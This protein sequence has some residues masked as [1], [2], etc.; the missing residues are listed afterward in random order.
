MGLPL[1]PST[2][3]TLKQ[4]IS[5]LGGVLSFISLES[6]RPQKIMAAWP[7]IN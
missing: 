3:G 7:L 2:G 6:Q 1:P 4:R 5:K